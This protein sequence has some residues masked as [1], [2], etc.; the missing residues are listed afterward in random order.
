MAIKTNLTDLTPARERFR[1]EVTLLS[2]GY[3]AQDKLP[4]GRITIYPWD[5]KVDDWLLE[6]G[7]TGNRETILYD[8]ISKVCAL[9]GLP[10]TSLLVSDAMTIMMVSR[11]MQHNF[12]VQYTAVCPMCRAKEEATIVVPDQLGRVGE[13][14]AD[15]PGFEDVLLE[16]SK[17]L[18]SVRPLTI[19]DEY[20]IVQRDPSMRK[21]ITDRTARVYA[22][23][24]AV[25]GGS[26]DDINEIDTWYNAL[27]PSDVVAL[28][29]AVNNAEPKLD[30]RIKHVCDSCG[31]SF[32]YNLDINIDFFR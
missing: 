9:N 15:Y 17:D 1:K 5:S 29:E 32:V 12:Q 20:A 31:S 10:V 27:P 25:N 8:A 13:K 3:Y 2:H 23:V 6:R 24:V 28:R 19:N 7:K 26:P 4:D 14:K 18:V 11:S 16:A 30:T 22:A 21:N